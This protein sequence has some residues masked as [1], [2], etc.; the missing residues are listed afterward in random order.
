MMLKHS[1]FLA[2]LYADDKEI[3]KSVKWYSSSAS[4]NYP[5]S[6]YR[7]GCYYESGHGVALD[8]KKAFDL[9]ELS[10]NEGHI[11]AKKAYAVR[12]MKGRKG[13]FGFFKG[14]WIY[15]A[16]FFIT[17]KVMS[18]DPDSERLRI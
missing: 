1:F 5:P 11:F 10:A 6:Q 12:L 16:I 2:R 4:L 3:E 14:L 9:F 17:I 18:D 8:K 13:I 7:L 15:V